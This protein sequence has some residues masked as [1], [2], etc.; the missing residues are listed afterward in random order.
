MTYAE[1]KDYRYLFD[2]PLLTKAKFEHSLLV[3]R[4]IRCKLNL[5]DMLMI[6]K[7]I[8]ELLNENDKTLP[9]VRD[10]DI[11]TIY[12]MEGKKFLLIKETD[13]LFVLVKD[14]LRKVNP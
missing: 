8:D 14:L 4:I 7:D 6:K 10:N 12:I 3:R 2:S 9:M 11:Y 5:W 13:E 1:Y